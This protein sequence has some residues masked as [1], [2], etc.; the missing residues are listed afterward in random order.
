MKKE[1]TFW[2]ILFIAAAIF[3]IVNRLGLIPDINIWKI[4]FTV[5]VGALLIK[6]IVKRDITGIL[7][8]I[9]FVC[10]IFDRELGIEALTPWTVLAAAALGSIGFSMLCKPKKHVSYTCGE[11]NSATAMQG[12]H[13]ESDSS[14]RV[15]I[16]NSFGTTTKH[17]QSNNL[18]FI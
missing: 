16:R 11:Q 3:L 15:I 1:K 14:N 5:L 7:F 8:S 6:S 10:I 2:G 13:E 18:E 9:A 17:M 12:E 4:I